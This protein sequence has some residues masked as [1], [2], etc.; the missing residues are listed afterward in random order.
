MSAQTEK[1]HERL[2]ELL[3]EV[4]QARLAGKEVPESTLGELARTHEA[5]KHA[6][7]LL[8]ESNSRKT[9]ND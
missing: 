8:T 2:K 4:K 3:D 6:R 5:I 1:L 9:L 7:N